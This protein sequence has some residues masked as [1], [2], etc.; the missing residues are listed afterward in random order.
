MSIAFNEEEIRKA[1][2]FLHPDG[3]IFEVR[4][5][6]GKWNAAGV[7]D[8]ADTLIEQLRSDWLSPEANVYMTLNGLNPACFDRKHKNQFIKSMSPTVSDNDVIGYDWLFIDVDPKR[9]S[10]TSST[11]EQLQQSQMTAKRIYEF[12]RDRGWP[13]PIGANSGNGTHLLYK[14]QLT[15][16]RE[17]LVESVLQVLNM[18]FDDESMDIDMR[19]FNPSRICKLYGTVARKGANTEK[20]PHRMSSI[21]RVPDKI[22]KVPIDLLQALVDLLPRQEKPQAYNGYNPGGFDLQAWID[23]H[24]IE[25]RE[26]TTWSGGTKWILDHCPF[27]PQ[28]N[29][30]DAAIVQTNDG[31]ICYNCFHNSCADKHWREFRLFYEPDAYQPREI[32]PAVPNYM[33]TRPPDFG[34]P[35]D[36][37]VESGESSEDDGE[38][39]PVWYTTEEIR[40]R[41]VPDEAFIP[42]GIQDLDRRMIGLKKGYVSVLSGLRSAGKS[43]ILSQ[44][45]LTCRQQGMK[46]ALFS[47][48]MSDKQVLKWLARQAAGKAYVQPTSYENIYYPTDE[49]VELVSAWLNEFVYVYNNDYGNQFEALE[50]RLYAIIMQKQLDLVLIDNLMAMNIEGLD[51]DLYV[52]QTKF[53]RAL[54][55]MAQK[56][57]VHVLFVAHPRK[58]QGYL[59][60]DDISGSGDLSNAADNVFIIHRVDTDYKQATQQFFRWTSNNPLYSAGNVIEICKDRDN[61]TRDVHIPLY[62]EVETKRFKN[63]PAEYIHYGWEEAAGIAAGAM[64]P[65]DDEN[66]PW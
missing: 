17:K 4:L 19:T 65:A 30:K 50:K 62:F 1:I 27:N 3:D 43:S 53:V 36:G 45:V 5:V 21:F 33:L 2:T 24:H 7:F 6:D 29:H 8:S 57:N 60:M 38:P 59:R 23:A 52:R 11:K 28:H 41:V 37:G 42:T 31:K 9:P 34:K 46:C 15:V 35:S 39:R 47:G 54:K 51:H 49:T 26:R 22:E 44:L 12:L 14:V 32:Q 40:L 48:E 18:L 64:I 13:E 20:R 56:L 55:R 58:S 63:K 10:G 16:D 66:V 61:G 25:V